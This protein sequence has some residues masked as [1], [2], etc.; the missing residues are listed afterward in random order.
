MNYDFN[1][2]IAGSEI[3][4]ANVTSVEGFQFEKRRIF[5]D[6][7]LTLLWHSDYISTGGRNLTSTIS[8]RVNEAK[9]G[10]LSYVQL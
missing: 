2:A 1:I 9:K 6:C 10:D 8:L 3:T 5:F 7:R 4:W